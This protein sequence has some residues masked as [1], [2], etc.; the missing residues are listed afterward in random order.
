MLTHQ[1]PTPSSSVWEQ[2]AHSVMMS[3]EAHTL[4][5]RAETLLAAT[6]H[7]QLIRLKTVGHENSAVHFTERKLQVLLLRIFQSI[8][9]CVGAFAL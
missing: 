5:F 1:Y 4:C 8:H 9:S 6:E 2:Q 7:T 3:H